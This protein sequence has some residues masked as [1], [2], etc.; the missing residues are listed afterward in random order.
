MPFLE[1]MKTCRKK[2]VYVPGECHFKYCTATRSLHAHACPPD[3][4]PGDC[5]DFID[6]LNAEHVGLDMTV[7]QCLYEA[8]SYNHGLYEY[9]TGEYVDKPGPS[10][11]AGGSPHW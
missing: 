11:V 10:G 2:F 5:I 1:C 9:E 8:A 4:P 6:Q 7:M 3:C